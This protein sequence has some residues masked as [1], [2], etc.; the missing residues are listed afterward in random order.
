[1]KMGRRQCAVPKG[2]RKRKEGRN[3]WREERNGEKTKTK[4]GGRE[5]ERWIK[6]IEN[7]GGDDMLQHNS[8]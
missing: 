1:M 8:I 6:E 3:E 2:G 7:R 4:T 5:G